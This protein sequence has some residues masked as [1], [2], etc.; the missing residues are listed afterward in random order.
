MKAV[1][2]FKALIAHKRPPV[3]SSILGENDASRMSLP[4]L[5]ISVQKPRH[6]SLKHKPRSLEVYDRKPIEG[7]LTAEGVHRT[8]DP[9]EEVQPSLQS[10]ILAEKDNNDSPLPEAG[11]LRREATASPDIEDALLPF[12]P[13]RPHDQAQLLLHG[14]TVDVLGHRGHAH[15]PLEDHLYLRIGPSTFAGDTGE[16]DRRAS[17]MPD[18]D[19]I[20]VVSES[21]GAADVDIY[22]TAY[23]DEIERIKARLR[24]EGKEEEPQVYLTRRVDAKLLA[25][26]GLAG[27]LRSMGEGGLEKVGDIRAIKEGRV[28]VSG[29]SRALR[30]AAREEYERHRAERIARHQQAAE[31]SGEEEKARPSDI[32]T[33]NVQPNNG[34]NK[35]V[36]RNAVKEEYERHRA[37]RKTKHQPGGGASIT[38]L[39]GEATHSPQTQEDEAQ[40]PQRKRPSL[41][42]MTTNPLAEKAWEKSRQAKSSFKDMLGRMKDRGGSGGS[43]SGT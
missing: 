29:M 12:L 23:R 22:E 6:P 18:E 26:G 36:L 38:G 13:D 20:L 41:T 33:E 40:E 8:I 28:K 15:D 43:G 31:A 25:L 11:F 4:P 21:P 1:R 32:H 24:Q 14:H 35:R 7:A 19:D 5:S 27:R 37:E 34:Q 9:G 42:F 10:L 3:M 30:S 39:E 17:F 2:K 16:V